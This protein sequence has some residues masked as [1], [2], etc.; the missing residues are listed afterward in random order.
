MSRVYCEKARDAVEVA[1]AVLVPE[2]VALGV[3]DDRNFTVL[4]VERAVAGELQ[5]HVVF[6]GLL[7]HFWGCFS[8]GLASVE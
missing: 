4:C 3:G 1:L 8:S 7:Q 2:V 6:C 5:K